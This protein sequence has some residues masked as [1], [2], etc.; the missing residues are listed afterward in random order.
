MLRGSDIPIEVW[1]PYMLSSVGRQYRQSK[2]TR[3]YE[4]AGLRWAY[5]GHRKAIHALASADRIGWHHADRGDRAYANNF[6]GPQSRGSGNWL[7]HRT[8][9]L[10]RICMAI[11][12]TAHAQNSPPLDWRRHSDYFSVAVRHSLAC[13]I[14]NSQIVS[15]RANKYSY[16]SFHWIE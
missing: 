14:A 8:G 10:M 6:A 12:S 15:F 9:F 2:R 1:L 3:K 4:C 13:G 7:R 16:L 5:H 11:F